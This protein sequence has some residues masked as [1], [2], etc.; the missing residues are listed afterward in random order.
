MLE[1]GFFVFFLHL[2][3]N[4]LKKLPKIDL[5]KTHLRKKS[6]KNSSFQES[7][8]Q[9]LW[10]D[11]FSFFVYDTPK[12]YTKTKIW[13]SSVMFFPGLAQLTACHLGSSG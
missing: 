10:A 11:Q 12:K 9:V 2:K 7:E 5:P 1:N 3:F 8:Y 4:E 6:P 13:E